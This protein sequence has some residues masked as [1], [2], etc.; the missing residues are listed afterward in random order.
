M[1]KHSTDCDLGKT[2]C[3]VPMAMAILANKEKLARLIVP[4]ALLLQTA[5]TIQSRL[6]GL[7][8]REIRHVAYF[9]HTPTTPVMRRLYAELHM[10]VL[11]CCG[12]ILT[13]PEH[14]LSYRLSGLQLLADSKLEEARDLIEVQSWLDE[15]CRDV[16]DE[17]DFTLAV[18][19]Q[20]IYPSGSQ[21]TVD[22]GS[23]RWRVAQGVLSLVEDHLIQLQ[24]YFPRGVEVVKR[25]K[26][27]PM[28]YFPQKEAEDA[29]QRW[30]INDICSGKTPFLRLT[31]PDD[32][33]IDKIGMQRL[34]LE[35]RLDQRLFSDMTRIFADSEQASKSI[36]ILR[37]L[38]MNRILLLCLKKRWNV[39]YGL[40]PHRDPVA[41]PFEAKGV[42][43]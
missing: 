3:I 10:E 14:V 40:H 26:G 18:K 29:L 41:V 25:P 39:Q 31:N 20:L 12:V 8:G 21:M 17:S 34:L 23:Y 16:L 38:L 32:Q 30:I 6:G 15:N 13:T 2:S 1:L 36:L 24:R 43:S 11:N 22:G 19:T 33:S 9:R 28:M 5:Q 27:F 35:D 7:V 42:P 37:G 4:K